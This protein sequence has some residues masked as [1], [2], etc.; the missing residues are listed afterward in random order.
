MEQEYVV[1]AVRLSV[2]DEMPE[3]MHAILAYMAQNC[4]SVT[5]AST[6]R[7]FGCHPNT[8]SGAIRRTLRMS[9]GDLL[10]EM[11]MQR[12][13]AL[14]DSGLTAAQTAHYCG[15]DDVGRFYDA[16]KR[17]YTVTP[18]EWVVST[19]GRESHGAARLRDH[20]ACLA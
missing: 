18:H 16:F 12:A 5:L 2:P 6:A 20:A 7:R 17:R 9:F 14:L 15:Y 8:I 10:F 1:S 11:R 4:D 19:R 3:R 13:T